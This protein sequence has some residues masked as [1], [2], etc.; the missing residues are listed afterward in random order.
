MN[1]VRKSLGRSPTARTADRVEWESAP[2]CGF[3]IQLHA[4]LRA[5][6]RGLA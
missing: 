1:G 4:K 3:A 6:A 5:P 2:A